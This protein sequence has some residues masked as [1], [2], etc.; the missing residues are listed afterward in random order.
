[1][2]RLLRGR[3]T[4]FL[5]LICLS[6]ALNAQTATGTIT[7]RV[8]D[9]TAN[10]IPGAHLT[11]LNP[12]T[13]ETRTAET[14]ITGD[15]VMTGLQPRTYTLKVRADGFKELEKKDLTLTA[16]E[17]LSAGNL[18]LSIGAV[19][20]SVEVVAEATP[21]QTASQERSAELND[22]QM[23]TL[24]ARG[25]DFIG[26]FRVLPG[27]VGGGGGESLGTSGTPTINGVR[28]EYNLATIDGVVGNT[29]GL[30]TLD[31]PLN[32]DAIAE[33]KV[34]SAN[35]QAEYGKTA[36]SVITV[37]SKHGTQNVHGT[38]YYYIRNEAFNANGFFDNLNSPVSPAVRARYRYNTIGG[39]IGGPVYWPGKFNS[40]K[41]KLFA[42][43][44]EEYLPNVAR[45]GLK[46]YT[47]PTELERTGDLSKSVDLNNKL[48]VIKDPLTQQPLPGNVIPSNRIDP[49]MQK[50][51][52][53]FPQPNFT[54]F[55]ITGG[56]YNYN[57]STSAD[58]PVRQEIL[59]L[60]YVVNDRWR[61]F[62]RGMNEMVDNNGFNSPAN[63]LPWL[64]P[65]DYKTHNPNVAFNAVYIAS[66]TVVNELTLGAA[67]W[68]EDQGMATADL[69]KIEKD[70]L[71][72]SIGQRFPENNP[73]NLVPMASFGGISNAA[74]F[75]YDGRFPMHD[76]VNT[77]T[78]TDNVSK[79]WNRHTFK[80]GVD[81]Q[82]DQYLQEHHSGSSSFTGSYDFGRN[83]NNPFDTNY[84]YSNALFGYFNSYSEG[85]AR[86]DYKPRTNVVE[87][88]V[89]DN[90]RITPRLTLDLG[91]R[92]TWGLAQTLKTGANFVPALFQAAA[93]PLR[94][95]PGKDSKGTR[96]AIDPR[97]EQTF[98]AAYI[99]A[100]IAGTGNPSNGTIS[101]I[102]PA[103]YPAGS[104]LYGNGVLAAPRI[105]FA[106]DPFGDG[107]TAI[108]GG[109]GIF[110]NARA[111]SGQEG[112]LT[113]NP[114]MINNQQIYYGNTATVLS[115]GSISFPTSVNHAIETN[116]RML[117]SYNLSFGIQRN[118]GWGTVLDVAY[119]GT[120]GRHL[121][122]FRQI[123]TLMS[124]THFQAWGID[125]TTGK[126]YSDDFL[127][128]YQG[129]SNIPMQYFDITS[130]YHSL[131]TQLTH[132]F[133]H[134]LQFGGVWTWSK[135]MG[136]TDSYNG[137]LAT[138]ANIRFY[139]YG[140]ADSDRTHNVAVNWLW[141]IP[142]PSSNI[143]PMHAVF[144][145][146]QISGILT[147]ISGAPQN[148]SFSTVDGTDITGGG[149]GAHVFLT[150]PTTLPKD[151]RTFDRFF[152]KSV[153][154]RPAQGT[155]GNMPRSVFRGPGTNNW[156]LSLFKNIPIREKV[157]FQLRVEA[158]NAFNHT[159]F[160][161]VNTAAKF[162]LQGNQV[163]Q[164]FGQLSAA[165]SARVMQLATR[166]SF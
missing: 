24:M 98:P 37:V 39:N 94:Y 84:A 21:V 151:Q 111:R 91:V 92:F 157:R 77:L 127:R 63:K 41:N 158:Y 26:F 3:M 137:T 62:F 100:F 155:L 59:R 33:V 81:L 52:N 12:L 103:G 165:A 134:G 51:L 122:D 27:V 148:F 112:D 87:W 18:T 76:V 29:R 54:N 140:E 5:A 32:L 30:N 42:F 70:R 130:S 7:G 97:N 44:S 144:G 2:R 72:V 75:G 113:F 10:P 6:L 66:P 23:E 110:Y 150:G 82:G 104:L 56:Q 154:T 93:V 25:R 146:W 61:T 131:Q 17:R 145:N 11:L 161:D 162:D 96:V 45:E 31:T 46:K 135:T 156:D 121:S 49:N 22:K 141:D 69:Q 120:L 142:L 160:S 1:M 147:L 58:R 164:N 74:T 115:A 125:P 123:N 88:Y 9:Q 139:N 85:T 106:Y 28:S 101:T 102:N 136:Y 8:L 163:S 43:F 60:D 35:Y 16:S 65:V 95:V 152:K 128:P 90:W 129:Y 40:G 124:G 34:L 107:K 53:I 79:T 116:P 105:G 83:T 126:P 78:L 64:M 68:T 138:Y 55:A 109:F 132:R 108:R 117:A 50:M 48:I 57:T 14:E 159:Q 47:V 153:V 36:G 99:G 13:G 80:V 166:I 149:D 19:T 119:V 89:Q 114:P 143:R 73:L 133:R 38:G 86:L 118:V 20:D 4:A 71:G 67:L 15:F